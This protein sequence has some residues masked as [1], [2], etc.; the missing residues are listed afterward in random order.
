VSLAVDAIPRQETPMHRWGDRPGCGTAEGPQRQLVIGPGVLRVRGVDLAAA[1]RTA[2]RQARGHLV[3]IDAF[4][5]AAREERERTWEMAWRVDEDGE[6]VIPPEPECPRDERGRRAGRLITEWSSK[7]QSN[8]QEVFASLDFTT[9]FG[10]YAMCQAKSVTTAGRTMSCATR[11]SPELDRCPACGSDERQVLDKT[12]RLPAISTLT[13]PG[14]WLTV[15]PSSEA[16]KGHHTSLAKRFE[17]AWGEPLVMIWKQEFQRRE[18]PHLHDFHTPPPGR[19][20]VEL[21]GRTAAALAPGTDT[22][23][24]LCQRGHVRPTAD[25]NVVSVDFEG[26]LSIVWPE[27]VDHPDDE[28]FRKHLMAGTGVDRFK[29][30]TLRD[31]RRITAYFSGYSTS[32][33]KSYQNE[34]PRAWIEGHAECGD[35]REV[36]L[37]DLGECPECGSRETSGRVEPAGPGRYWGHRGLSRASVAVDVDHETAVKIAR[38]LR[39]WHRAEQTKRARAA[40]GAAAAEVRQSGGTAEEATTAAH[41]AY[42]GKLTRVVRRPRARAG[43]GRLELANHEWREMTTIDQAVYRD[44]L[45]VPLDV[46]HTEQRRLVRHEVHDVLGVAGLQF[47]EAYAPQQRRTRVRRRPITQDGRGRALLNDA[48]AFAAKLGDWLAGRG[49]DRQERAERLR[50]IRV[51]RVP[52]AA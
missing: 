44:T 33:N 35:C 30:M 23:A 48:P 42:V 20:A 31:P 12:D 18:A 25:P 15:A 19:I 40:A 16:V 3:E 5:L 49:P 32:K 21:E 14:D 26:W 39:K 24:K 27:I 45:G 9:M 47:V 34:P 10:H 36:Y 46:E 2:E 7:S 28:E 11:Y 22:R 29:A 51:P 8:M 41:R 37:G 1:E 38:S 17:R 6:I 13:Y 4:V 43:R 50:A 52:V